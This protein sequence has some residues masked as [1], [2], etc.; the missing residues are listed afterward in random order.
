MNKTTHENDKIKL[1]VFL[2]YYLPGSK[3]GGPVRTVA[4]MVEAL[5]DRI[6]FYIVT[7]DRDSG[8]TA[9]YS[10]CYVNEWQ[11]VGAANVYYCSP[12][13]IKMSKFYRLITDVDFDLIYFNS[14]FSYEFTIKP[15]MAAKLLKRVQSKRIVLAPRGE[16]SEGALTIKRR[17]KQLMLFFINRLSW[18]KNIYWH[19]SSEW[20]VK[21][22][23]AVVKVKDDHIKTAYNLVK[24]D[25][26]PSFQNK[27]NQICSDT[28]NIMFLSRISPKKNLLGALEILSHIK[29]NINFN[30]YGGISDADYWSECQVLIHKLPYNIKVKYFGHVSYDQVTIILQQNDLLLLPTLGENFGHVIVESIQVGTPV[31]ISDKTPWRDLESKGIGWDVPLGNKQAFCKAIETVAQMSSQEKFQWRQLILSKQ[32]EILNFSEIEQQNFH[33]FKGIADL[34]PS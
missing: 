24:R 8:D 17:K 12:D 21:D 20:E 23:N 14:F 7:L 11:K 16:F 33:L 31:L 25:S 9:P 22:I 13:S 34:L 28:C 4:N 19:A 32:D 1:L 18:L 30:I 10:G 2:Q 3:S 15:L 5:S 26:N 27:V 29:A 6:D